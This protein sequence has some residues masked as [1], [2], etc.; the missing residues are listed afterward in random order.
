MAR[1]ACAALLTFTVACNGASAPATKRPES[2]KPDSVVAG[3][4]RLERFSAKT[5]VVLIRGFSETAKLSGLY[6]S[7]VV[8]EARELVDAATNDHAY[9]LTVSVKE[10]TGLERR[11]T[12][13]IDYDE[14]ESL[15]RGLDYI[16]KVNKSA[17]RLANFQA[18]YR[19]RGDFELST[20]STQ[21]EGVMASVK[22]G[23]LGGATA[24]FS[25]DKLASL[26]NAIVQTKVV[27]DSV[28]L[29]ARASRDSSLSP[30]P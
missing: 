12:S 10:A 19:T 7:T 20:F 29:A 18:D 25:I 24:F 1:L 9:G 22:S 8:L 28:Q 6:G 3:K 4:T 5:G 30:P 26:R 17:T 27:L 2:A 14:I 15:L 13:Y 16:A 23:V 11:E 21:P